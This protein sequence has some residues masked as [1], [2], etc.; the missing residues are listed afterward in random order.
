MKRMTRR[1]SLCSLWTVVL[2]VVVFAFLAK[3]AAAG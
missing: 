2:A 1:I 3:P